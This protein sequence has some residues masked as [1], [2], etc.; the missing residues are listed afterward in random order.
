MSPEIVVENCQRRSRE[1]A[2]ECSP[3]RKAWEVEGQVTKPRRGERNYACRACNSR[4]GMR[5]PTLKKQR[6]TNDVGMN[7]SIP[8]IFRIVLNTILLQKGNELF[9]E[10]MLFMMFLLSGDVFGD[11]RDAGFTH[12]EYA[13]TGLP[14]ESGG[15]FSRTQR[16]ELVLTTRTIS[17]AECTGR[18]RI[19]MW[20]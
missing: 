5:L 8:D 17:A 14:R 13:V 16:D 18:A 7:H 1:A 10:R 9:L 19:N 12:A 3:R 11:G 15:M 4:L 6:S 2:K 20:T